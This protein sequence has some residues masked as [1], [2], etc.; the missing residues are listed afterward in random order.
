MYI[1]H[2]I[3]PKATSRGMFTGLPIGT[4]P[5][6]NYFLVLLGLRM[7]FRSSPSWMSMGELT[8]FSLHCGVL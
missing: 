6:G 2:D 4:I 1:H 8:D 7:D 3:W 5:K